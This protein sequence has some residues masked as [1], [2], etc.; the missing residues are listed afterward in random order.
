[1]V[2]NKKSK[3]HVL[4]LTDNFPPEVNAPATRTFEHALRWVRAGHQV[5]VITCVP[6]FPEGRIFAGYENKW[7]QREHIDGIDVVRVKTYIAANEGFA[8][9]ILDFLSFM[10]M[11]FF[12]ALAQK[13]PDLIV[14]TSP[15]FFTAVSGYLVSVVR[16]R[17]FLFEVRD[18]WPAS[19]TAV[20]SI[21]NLR[22][23]N[24]LEK[25]ELFLY[26]RATGI[27]TVTEAFKND[28]TSRGV[29]PEKIEVVLNGVDLDR[30][31]PVQSMDKPLAQKYGLTD[32]FVAAYIG[33]MGMAHS[34][35]T[36]LE[37][38]KLLSHRNDIRIVL[39]GGGAKSDFAKS[40]V[41]QHKL[42]NVVLIPRQ[43][44]DKMPSIWSICD[45]SLVTLKNTPIFS[46]VIPSKMFEAM[47]M[48]IPIIMAVP[49]GEATDIIKT[50]GSG[51]VV[52]PE[53]HLELA[54][55]IERLCD[56]RNTLHELA[57]RSS[58]A[59]QG[60]SRDTAADKMLKFMLKLSVQ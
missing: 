60:F 21:R 43:A 55:E 32:K 39:A 40:F 45:V 57:T 22:I 35:E 48:G 23:I 33:T 30:Y 15:Q 6:N 11:S 27:V 31:R 14:A 17:P 47:G 51:V 41:A 54:T 12:A 29:K 24:M 8:K 58:E 36:I 28:L 42:T 53:K 2:N 52:S 13:K 5:T 9:R 46:T 34:L 16:K 1:M 18:L 7:Y 50:T 44:K 4:F 19:I 56:D 20:G 59:A 25:L 49:K 38:A 3:I 26:D 37:A 10:L